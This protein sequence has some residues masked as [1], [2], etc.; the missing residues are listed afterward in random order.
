MAV[1]EQIHARETAWVNDF[2]RSDRE[3]VGGRIIA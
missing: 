2:Q 1:A 3:V